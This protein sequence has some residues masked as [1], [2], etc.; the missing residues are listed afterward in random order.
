M[1]YFD[2]SQELETSG[3]DIEEFLDQ[4]RKHEEKRLENELERVKSQLEERNEI[5]EKITQELETKLAEYR[6]RLEL[7]Y[8]QRRGKNGKRDQ[9]KE[10]IHQLSQKLQKERQQHWKDKQKLERERRELISDIDD[11]SLEDL[12]TDS[13]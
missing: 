11:L 13:L 8:K 4:N 7:M 3:F 5:H 6:E 10:R 12:L 1:D 9:V 2:Y